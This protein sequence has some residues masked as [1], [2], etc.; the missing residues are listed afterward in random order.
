MLEAGRQV[1]FEAEVK[2]DGVALRASAPR[3]AAARHLRA[4]REGLQAAQAALCAEPRPLHQRRELAAARRRPRLHQGVLRQREGPPLHRARNFSW[5]RCARSAA[6]PTSG[7]AS[8]CACPTTTSRP[9]AATATA[10]TG[11]SPMPT[12]PPTTTRSTAI[13]AF[14]ASRENLPWLP[15]SIY[16]RPMKLNPAEVHMRDVAG[17]QHGWVRHPVPARRH[18]RGARAQQ[19]PLALLRPRRLLPPRRRLRHPRGLRFARPA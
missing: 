9:R 10:S 1:D 12:S 16:Q 7:A 13:S 8:R 11:R 2:L 6:R 15:D 17:Q 3:Q 18:H 19:V 4:R 14:R 5:V